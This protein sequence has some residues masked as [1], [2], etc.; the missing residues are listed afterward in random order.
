[1][2][3][4]RHLSA[5]S[6]LAIA[7]ACAASPTSAQLIV[8]DPNN[9]AQNVLTAA[10]ELQQINNQITS[11][12]NQAQ[13]LINQAKNLASLPYSSLQQLEQSIQRTQAASRPGP[14]HCLRYQA[15]RSSVLDDLCAGLDERVRSSVDRE[16]A[17]TLAEFCGGLAG[18]FARSGDRG[19][20][21]R[22]PPQRDVGPR[23]L[24]PGRD[25]RAAGQPGRKSA[26]WSAGAATRR[27][28]GSSCRAGTGAKSRN[29]P[30]YRRTGP[31]QGAASSLSR[32][33][34]RLSALDSADVSPMSGRGGFKRGMFV[35]TAAVVSVLVVA[36]CTIQL[37]GD[38]DGPP[39][40][41]VS[42]PRN[43]SAW[44]ETRTL[45]EG[46]LRAGGR[47]AGVP[48]DLG[49][50][51]PSLPGIKENVSRFFRRCSTKQPDT[52]VGAA[53]ESR[54]SSAGL[55][56]RCNARTRVIPWVA[57]ASSIDFWKRLPAISTLA[58]GCLVTKS[59]SS[60]RRSPRSIS[61]WPPCSGP[62]APTRTSSLAL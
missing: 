19:R 27:P 39:A 42:I 30:A 34:S 62:G 20:Q 7:I 31:G 43:Q 9:Y 47:T 24:K 40:G 53:Q 23:Q 56:A 58:L 61:R 38:S 59:P 11:L 60:R 52:F 21:S 57:P 12:Q 32:T 26:P 29:C 35:T 37:R 46:H 5:V 54:S 33:G 10:R 45:P 41:S 50:E 17:N 3:R 22:H 55:A 6:A 13:M 4:R 2:K 15:D 25:R 14:A 44:R 1:M 51:P 49:G 16:C 28:N 48:S 36:A 18:C 8:F